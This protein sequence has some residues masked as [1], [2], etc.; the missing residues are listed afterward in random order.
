MLVNMSSEAEKKKKIQVPPSTIH[1]CSFVDIA[2]DKQSIR[3]APRSVLLPENKFK[4]G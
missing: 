1:K 3:D 2:S 4:Y